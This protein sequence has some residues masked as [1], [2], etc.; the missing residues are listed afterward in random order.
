MRQNRLIDE[1]KLVESSNR[2]VECFNK[3]DT[4]MSYYNDLISKSNVGRVSTIEYYKFE[5]AIEANIEYMTADTYIKR[6]A[7][8]VFKSSI[9]R[10]TRGLDD[11]KISKYA[12]LMKS[13]TKFPMPILD[14]ANET[15]EGRH[16]ML[17]MSRAYGEDTEGAVLVITRSNPSDKEIEEYAIKKWGEEYKDFGIN[18][19]N[20][21]I[22]KSND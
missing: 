21:I 14:I 19:V 3:K 16:R 8:E 2:S 9:S 13:G 22:K 15:Q 10:T 17:A 4:G 7:N 12:E 6:C 18:Y 5:K 11:D 20:N 1:I